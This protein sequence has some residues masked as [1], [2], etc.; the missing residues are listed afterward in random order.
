MVHPDVCCDKCHQVA[1]VV[2]YQCDPR[3]LAAIGNLI[4]LDAPMRPYF[5]LDCPQCG[6]RIQEAA[7]PPK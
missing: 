1:K 4:G 5:V 3:K 6:M 2:L 7:A